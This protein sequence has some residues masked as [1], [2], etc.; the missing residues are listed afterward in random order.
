MVGYQQ[1]TACSEQRWVASLVGQIQHKQLL[2]AVHNAHFCNLLELSQES[3]ISHS[4][5]KSPSTYRC[6]RLL[7]ICCCKVFS[8]K[9]CMPAFEALYRLHYYLILPKSVSSTSLDSLAPSRRSSA[10]SSCQSPCSRAL[11]QTTFIDGSYC[12]NMMG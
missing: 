5:V 6:K 3:K 12:Q 2:E 7:C 1:V 8:D 4:Y 11:L 10:Q 9:A